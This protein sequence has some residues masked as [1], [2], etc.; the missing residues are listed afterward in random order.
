MENEEKSSWEYKP[1]VG[2]AANNLPDRGGGSPAS[3]SQHRSK[4]VSWEAPE[5]IDH[6]RGSGWYLALFVITLALAAGV[7][8]LAKDT[9]ATVIIVLLGIIVGVF[10]TQKPSQAKYEISSDGLNINGKSYS[11][12]NYKSFAIINEGKLSSVNL[13]PIKR[14][15][16]PLSAYFEPKDEK[17]IT[18]ILGDYLPYEDRQL[19]AVERLAR[20][21][22]L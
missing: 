22:R 21:L 7:Y 17:K 1:D 8:L 6:Q 12:G 13:F 20:R 11:F 19:D 5:F 14:L 3:T 16:P 2:S 10:A 9:F 4:S 18:G 15:M